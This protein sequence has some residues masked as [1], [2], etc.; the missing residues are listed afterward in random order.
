MLITDIVYKVYMLLYI[1]KMF[2]QCYISEYLGN[3]SFMPIK[4]FRMLPKEYNIHYH[5]I[6][7][8]FRLV[9]DAVRSFYESTEKNFVNA[10]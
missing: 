3:I 2:I 6:F 5:T 4:L 1:N 7:Q 10:S 8:M 9:T